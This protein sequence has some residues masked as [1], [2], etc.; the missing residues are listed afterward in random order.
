M[1]VFATDHP[2]ASEPLVF[3]KRA[4]WRFL[5]PEGWQKV[6]GGRSGAKTP[7]NGFWNLAHPGVM[8]ELCAPSGVDG[9]LRWN[10]GGVAALGHR[11]LSEQA[12]GLLGNDRKTNISPEATGA[13]LFVLKASRS[14]RQ[15]G[16]SRVASSFR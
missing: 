6:A 2:L 7:G 12:A 13:D 16:Q 14:P 5:N 1:N 15:R 8:P 11:L 3:S 4:S 10:S 9:D